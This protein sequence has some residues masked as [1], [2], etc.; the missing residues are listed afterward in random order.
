[1]ELIGLNKR[2][3]QLADMI[4]QQETR[5]E[6]DIMLDNLGNERDKRDCLL[7]LKLMMLEL[8]DEDVDQMQ[9]FP[10]VAEY[11]KQF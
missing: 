9:E 4:W 5:E 1:M 7:L 3:R 10:K 8:L 6:L 11:L 2:Q